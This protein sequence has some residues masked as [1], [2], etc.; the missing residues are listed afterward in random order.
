V[1]QY[2]HPV[3][4]QYTNNDDPWQRNYF[5]PPQFKKL[6]PRNY[7][8]I[9]IR[10][11]LSCPDYTPADLLQSHGF[12]VVKQHSAALAQIFSDGGVSEHALA[13]LYHPEIR[14]LVRKT[15]GAKSVFI[16]A[17]VFRRGK[18]A[19]EA[20]KLPT[21]VGYMAPAAAADRNQQSG[22]RESRPVE[23]SAEGT[24]ESSAESS[25]E[26]PTETTQADKPVN[27]PRLG[28]AAPVRT[29]H[30]DFTPL[31]ARQTIR[32]Q[33]QDIYNTAVESGVIAAEDRICQNQPFRA[34]TK[35]ADPL[36]AEQYNQKDKL[37][38]RY[39]AYSI[40]RPLKKVERD[41]ITLAPRR[42]S[43]SCDGE[44]VYWPYLNRIPGH[45]ELGGD[46]LKQYAMLGV[47]GEERPNIPEKGEPLKWYYLPAQEPD[48]VLFI[49]LFDSA[50]LGTNA[51]YAGAPWHASPEIGSV[52]GDQPRE[53]IDIRVL[54]FW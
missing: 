5:A 53:S 48:E 22:E 2:M 50:S 17:S 37:G 15:T 8:L 41:P 20:Y 36:I 46:Y 47:K 43:G 26:K 49:Q 40:W 4:N 24:A 16:T 7:P 11:S 54:A 9:D 25:A 29:P 18:S 10:P 27:Q 32:F 1:G 12:G 34:P 30:L 13:D 28:Q 52:E 51:Q 21:R 6:V 39:A 45:A 42:E 31:G 19:P 35:E 3:I 23:K 33:K 38:P 14:E 44:M